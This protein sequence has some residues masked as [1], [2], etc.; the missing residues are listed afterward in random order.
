MTCY[1]KP[2]NEDLDVTITVTS[3]TLI[4]LLGDTKAYITLDG[5]AMDTL[6]RTN[7]QYEFPVEGD[8]RVV[9]VSSRCSTAKVCTYPVMSE[10]A[11]DSFSTI[12]SVCV[13]DESTNDP[14]SVGWAKVDVGGDT[15]TSVLYDGE[16]NVLGAN[17]SIVKCC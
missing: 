11:P 8:Y 9:I 10:S 1:T 13:R 6:S 12:H 7:D 2:K 16:G 17:F 4:T 15:L 5:V 3:P 14:A